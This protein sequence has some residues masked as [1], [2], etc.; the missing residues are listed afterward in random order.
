MIRTKDLIKTYY[1]G[2]ITTTA[3]SN[4]NINIKKGEFAAIYGLP[5]SG[6]TTLL[7]I[8]GLVDSP[9]SGDIYF[10]EFNTAQK[11]EH[12]RA[13]IRKS[14]IGYI[15]KDFNLIDDMTVAENVS[16]PLMYGSYK[17]QE[18][19][20]L[21]DNVLLKMNIIHL[22]NTYPSQ[23]TGEQQQLTALARAII[24][25]PVLLIADEPTGRLDSKAGE[26]ILNILSQLNEE[27]MTIIM[28]TGSKQTAEH[29]RRIIQ[30]FDGHILNESTLQ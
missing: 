13:K 3:L 26:T 12:E 18:K 10:M 20:T 23:L 4:I 17:R 7:S 9:T 24:T 6:K 29:A 1:N 22:K 19:I 16:L 11:K 8:L 25:N 14:N 15:F 30:I 2:N 28:S 5:G 27:G 21:L